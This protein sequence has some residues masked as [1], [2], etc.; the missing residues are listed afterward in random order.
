MNR[1]EQCGRALKLMA[2]VCWRHDEGEIDPVRD[3]GSDHAI[4]GPLDLM[5]AALIAARNELEAEAA[6]AEAD[7]AA[8]TAEEAKQERLAEYEREEQDER[9]QAEMERGWE[10][11]KRMDAT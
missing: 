2:V 10:M 9:M 3:F 5:T 7:A 8:M 6:H 1:E 11:Q 4:N